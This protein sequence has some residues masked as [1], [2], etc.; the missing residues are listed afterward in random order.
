MN[1]NRSRFKTYYRTIFLVL[2]LASGAGCGGGRALI[3][4]APPLTIAADS[5][6]I[7]R[8]A[9][10]RAIDT[11]LSDSLLFQANRA[12]YIIS[13][14]SNR[15]IY[16]LNR[17]SLM[18]PA[19]VNKLFVT[20]AA[21]R[22]LGINHRFRTAV[23]GDS[24][25]AL[26]R[27]KGDLY[28]KGLGDPELKVADL[29][30]LAYRLR[31]MGLKQVTGN[32]I[33]DAGYFD[34]TSFGYGWMWDEG[35]YAYNAPVSALSLNRNTFEIGLRPG[36]RPGRRPRAEL[37]PRTAYLSIENQATTVKAGSQARIRADRSFTGAGDLVRITGT[38][39]ADQGL[40]YLV[41]T[42]TNP[43][44]YCGTV[45]R[46][47]LAAN[48]IRIAG[49]VR[50]GSTPPEK[51]ELSWHVSPP[52]YQIIRHMNKESDNFTAEMIFRRLGNGQDSI[53]P[54]P[55]KNNRLTEML[56]EMGFGQES[57]RMADGSG[58]SRYNL[59]TAEQ[60]VAVLS[61]AYRDPALR[62]ELLSSLPI[63]GAD[64]TLARRLTEDQ[65]KGVIRAKTGTLTGV[66]SL[67]GFVSGPGSQT[68]CFAIMFNNYTSKANS[69]RALQDSIV[70]RLARA[71]P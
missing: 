27:I 51:P 70:A 38:M 29:E 63:A 50:A 18:V 39:A 52:L 58:L 25:D 24:I 12:V 20:A 34:T 11:I 4:P 6:Q 68:Y 10:G 54:D 23:H 16:S 40:S 9:L 5:F 69:V 57:F 19:S 62:P 61:E 14:D 59:C 41:R 35:P 65:H 37:N 30:A 26:G 49:T 42:V 43:A 56:K 28:L 13:L 33:A 44:L 60:L 15:E 3:P 8:E 53:T 47:A 64:G 31:A 1:I 17:S 66:S 32:L 45:F 36:S 2:S 21:Y 67:A 46:E 48:G 7:K 71:A 22:Q 55:A